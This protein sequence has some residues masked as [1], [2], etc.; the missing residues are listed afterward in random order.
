MKNKTVV[1]NSTIPNIGKGLFAKKNIKCG[2]I[3]VKYTGIV[4]KPGQKSSSNRSNIM[5]LDGYHL[6]CPE[7]CR[8]SFAN[9]PIK[10]TH[11]RRKL[12]ESLK[13]DKPFYDIYDN[14]RVNA[15]IYLDNEKHRAFLIAQTEIK[16][17]EEIFTHYGFPYWFNQELCIGFLGEDEIEENGFPETI[18]Q[19]PG[20]LN[21]IKKFYFNFTKLEAESLPSSTHLKIILKGDSSITMDIP[22]YKK[23]IQRVEM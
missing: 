8:A 4:K 3:I 12:M 19:Y 18:H 1:K 9:D 15:E 10:F 14:C 16:K 6:D 20:F 21:Y 5:F 11:K 22:N 7:S 2:E 23:I 13:S 17:D